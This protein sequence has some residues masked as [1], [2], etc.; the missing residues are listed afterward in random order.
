MKKAKTSKKKK[1]PIWTW[2]IQSSKPRA[3]GDYITYEARLNEDGSISCNCP[4]WIFCKAKTPSD[5]KCKHTNVIKDESKDIFKKWKKGEMDE[6]SY[7]SAA[8]VQSINL[9]TKLLNSD[10]PW[11]GRVLTLDL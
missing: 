7:I 10:S 9:K 11:A 4:G 6:L 2:A 8:D 5:K 3:G 1:E